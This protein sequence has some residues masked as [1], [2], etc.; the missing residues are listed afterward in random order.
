MSD[1]D[2]LSF[3]ALRDALDT[4]ALFQS[5]FPL[6]NELSIE[7]TSAAELPGLERL[8]E[9]MEEGRAQD[10]DMCS[11]VDSLDFTLA[12]PIDEEGVDESCLLDIQLLLKGSKPHPPQIQVRQPAFLNRSQHHSVSTELSSYIQAESSTSGWTSSDLLLGAVDVVREGASRVYRE[13]QVEEVVDEAPVEE[14]GELQRT[15]FW[16]PSLS[17]KEKRQDFVDYSHEFKLTGFVMAGTLAISVWMLKR[18]ANL[19][20]YVWKGTFR[21]LIGSW[22][23]SSLNLGVIY[24]VFRKR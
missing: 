13:G 9:E 18:K 11:A 12:V 16:F 21:M 6:E 5:M 1:G 2:E 20:Y 14:L 24:R 10:M 8:V 15:W 3:A 17:S 23:L 22:R 19:V 4:L 7:P